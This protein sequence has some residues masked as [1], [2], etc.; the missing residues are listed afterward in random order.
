[1]VILT[2]TEARTIPL[3]LFR[4]V[5]IKNTDKAFHGATPR[6]LLEITDPESQ[7]APVCPMGDPVS[8]YLLAYPLGSYA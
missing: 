8:E 7:M 3:L 4:K 1:M 6:Q 5:F 2:R